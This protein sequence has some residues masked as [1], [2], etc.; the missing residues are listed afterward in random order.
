MLCASQVCQCCKVLPNTELCHESWR[1][2]QFRVHNDVIKWKQFPRYWPFVRE[3]H[4]SPVDS[5][6]R[7][8]WRGTLM[9]SLISA[10]TKGWANNRVAGDLIR[11]WTH[12]DVTVLFTVP[13]YEQRFN[14]NAHTTPELSFY[15]VMVKNHKCT[16]NSLYDCLM[17]SET[18]LRN[19]SSNGNIFRV[20]VPLCE[21][22][23]GDRWIPLT[24][25]SDAELWCIL[26]SKSEQKFEQTIGKQMIWDAVVHII[27][28]HCIVCSPQAWAAIKKFPTRLFELLFYVAMV[29]SIS[30]V[31]ITFCMI[32][33]LPVK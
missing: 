29:K 30:N 19:M 31:P 4:R 8:Q 26:W 24:D 17:A 28:R 22:T 2:G 27:W 23:T 12:Y 11:H 7:G 18:R 33:S 10:W 14:K 9:F 20:T 16:H 32:A 21:E 5:P 3:I 6:H 13:G 25:V 1:E 15:V